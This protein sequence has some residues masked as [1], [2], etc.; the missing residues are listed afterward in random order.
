MKKY[1]FYLAFF[2]FTTSYL[3]SQNLNSRMF[4]VLDF[5]GRPC[6]DYEVFI[7]GIKY[8]KDS[9]NHSF[10]FSY[11][12]ENKRY[13]FE[14]RNTET[15]IK[16]KFV[17]NTK[18]GKL[19]VLSQG[20]VFNFLSTFIKLSDENYDIK[21]IFDVLDICGVTD[22]FVETFYDGK[23]IYHSSIK[24]IG[25]HG[26]KDYLKEV[27][28]E[29]EKRGIRIHAII[30]TLC[31]SNSNSNTIPKD[32]LMLNRNGKADE[33][34]EKDKIFVSPSNPEVLRILSNLVEEI[35]SSYPTLYGVCLDNLRF[36]SGFAD[37][38]NLDN[39]DFGYE[40]STKELFMKANNMDPKTITFDPAEN[41]NWYKWI[42]FKEDLI[43]NLS[44]KLL[45]VI[46][47]KNP[48]MIFTASVNPNYVQQRGR[49]LECQYWL[50][51]INLTKFDYL[52][53]RCSGPKNYMDE[54]E[55]I[56]QYLNSSV[57]VINISSQLG[58]EPLEKQIEAIKANSKLTEFG[59]AKFDDLKNQENQRILHNLVFIK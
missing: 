5:N 15:G 12:N 45:S 14:I 37:Q 16:K 41:S 33:G 7:D 47:K 48:N 11:G 2:L 27:L 40:K 1:V 51:F 34:P 26:N 55:K 36:K 57:I 46:K 23:T 4:T 42:T 8:I 24:E 56:E 21:R 28:E 38:G 9:S 25:Q 54:I 29:G 10:S 44:V 19:D 52:L 3:L 35:S 6:P 13:S 53:Q 58:Y 50:D 22:L 20:L 30:N 39:N 32:F 31:W 59:I 43:T 49:N 18:D 17:V